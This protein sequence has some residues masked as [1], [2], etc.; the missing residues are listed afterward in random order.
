MKKVLIIFIMLVFVMFS[1]KL[2]KADH[3]RN[4]EELNITNG[5]LID[6]YTSN[7]LSSHYKE[8]DKRKFTFFYGL[9]INKF[10]V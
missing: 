10:K 7:E 8:V 9:N 3:Y 1:N 6:Q 4:F 5:K 2:I